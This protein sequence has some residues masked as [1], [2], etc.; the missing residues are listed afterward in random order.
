MVEQI[1]DFFVGPKFSQSIGRQGW[2][3]YRGTLNSCVDAASDAPSAVAKAIKM[4]KFCMLGGHLAQVHLREGTDGPWSTVWC[5]PHQEP[6]F[7]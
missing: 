7:P 5:P 1:K 4:A 3:V 2:L 6:R